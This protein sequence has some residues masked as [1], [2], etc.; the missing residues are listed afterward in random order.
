MA[1]D[2]YGMT[3]L[4]AAAVTGHSKVVEY[5][6]QRD[7]CSRE[8]KIA[9]LELLGATYVDKKRD[10]MGA[11]AYWKRGMLERVRDP[12]HIVDKPKSKLE[13][14]AYDN[15]IEA[16]TLEELDELISDP[17]DMRM[18]ALLVRERILGPA[19]PDTS[20]YIRYRGAVYADL[21][22]FERCI[23]LWMYALDMQ[24]CNL[25]PLNLMTQSSFLSF[26]ELFSFMSSEGRTRKAHPIKICDVIEVYKKAV[27]EVDNGIEFLMKEQKCERDHQNFNRLLV[28]VMHLLSL[29][30]KQIKFC[31][32]EDSHTLK[33]L[34][35]RMVQRKAT[36]EKGFN[37][38]HLA[39][40]KETSTVGKY[41]VC[42]FPSSEVAQLLIEVGASTTACDLEGNTPLHI[43]AK[44]KPVNREIMKLLLAHGAHIDASNHAGQTAEDLLHDITMHDI[45]CPINYTS[46]QCLAAKKVK[47][48]NIAY[49][50]HISEKLVEFLE[51]H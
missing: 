9:A 47:Q 46:L 30:S 39:A 48:S 1:K 4:R 29:I 37:V 19:H 41:P 49:K 24:Q 51:M 7:Q 8:E 25:D 22:N 32:K 43:A 3:P 14:S 5:L 6:I 18:Q 33:C 27:Q 45:V 11:L 28:I 35:Y 17:D 23:T 38:L 10:M 44:N 20:Y 26:A 16:R 34:V 31:S 12:S 2:C 40:C 21:G 36:G 42:K 50:E 13:N 15:A